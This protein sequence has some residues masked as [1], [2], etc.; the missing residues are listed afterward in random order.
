MLAAGWLAGCWLVYYAFY[1]FYAFP[2]ICFHKVVKIWDY[3]KRGAAACRETSARLQLPAIIDSLMLAAGRLAWLAGWL[4]G[5]LAASLLFMDF[6]ILMVFRGSG[7]IKF[8]RNLCLYRNL[9]SILAA[10]Y[11]RVMLAAGCLAGWLRACFSWIFKI[12]MVFV[13][14]AS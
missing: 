2:W 8:Y 10:C 6:I 3:P 11:H 14:L 4:A 7:F 9:C 13:N 12:S 5:W 1:D